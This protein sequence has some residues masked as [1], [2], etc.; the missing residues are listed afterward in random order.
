MPPNDYKKD[1]GKAPVLDA[2][3]PFYPALEALARCMD[4]MQHKHKLTGSVDPFNQWKQLP[5]AKVRLANAAA[6]HLLRGPWKINTADGSHTHAVHALFGLLASITIHEEDNQDTC[7]AA[8]D[9]QVVETAANGRRKFWPM[10]PIHGPA[11][12]DW[13]NLTCTCG[14]AIRDHAQGN[15]ECLDWDCSCA[16][17]TA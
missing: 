12:A 4:D 10:E 6:R 3:T 14:H 9:A 8:P 16:S 1:D 15:G 5:Q 2:L 11:G 13:R 17:V 7:C